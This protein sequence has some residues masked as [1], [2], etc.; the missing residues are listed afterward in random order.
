MMYRLRQDA[1][2]IN[3]RMGSG[4]RLTS[5]RCHEITWPSSEP[6]S[7]RRPDMT[8]QP[9]AAL[10]SRRSRSLILGQNQQPPISA[11]LISLGLQ[12]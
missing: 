10:G 3:S 12:Q 9:C 5:R 6:A 2:A 11:D 7:Q 1:T 8:R 4:G